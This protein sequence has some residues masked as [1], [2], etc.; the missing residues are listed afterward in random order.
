MFCVYSL[1]GNFG[2][3]SS[4]MTSRRIKAHAATPHRMPSNTK[5][6]ASCRPNVPAKENWM[7]ETANAGSGPIKTRPMVVAAPVATTTGR[8]VRFETSG[9]RIS[10]ANSTPPSGV[11]KV[12]AIPAPAPAESKVI[13]C[14][15]DS[16][17]TCA[18]AEPSAEPIWMIGPS[19]PTAAPLP[20]DSAE[21]SAL[22][23]ATL[24]RM[25]PC[26]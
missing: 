14:Q 11:L 7:S 1:P 15:V 21:A 23:I 8:N 26:L 25:L 10:R 12:A 19:R 22:T 3:P 16:R 17:I 20:I 6:I 4:M 13:F 18:N 9:S 5:A 2:K 24:P